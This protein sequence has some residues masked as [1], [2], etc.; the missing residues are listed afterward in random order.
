MT[1][2][3]SSQFDGDI[4][5]QELQR[6]REEINSLEQRIVSLE[7]FESYD[8]QDVRYTRLLQEKELLITNLCAIRIKLVDCSS[9]TNPI[10]LDKYIQPRTFASIA[11]N[12][13]SFSSVCVR[14]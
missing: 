8:S 7:S 11:H 9:A 14:L 12:G 6:L 10:P 4:F 2:T 13:L 5:L 1:D 3:S